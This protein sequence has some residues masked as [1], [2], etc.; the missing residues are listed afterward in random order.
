MIELLA[1]IAT[2]VALPFA[3]FAILY[4]AR[5]LSLARRAGSA[6]SVIALNDSL[7]DCWKHFTNSSDSIQRTYAFADLANAL[8]LACAAYHDEVFFG[9]TA[10]I[11]ENYLLRVF[12]LIEKNDDARKMM[13]EL[14]QTNTTFR[15]TVDFLANHRDHD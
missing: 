1:A 4:A 6:G 13:A 5:Q 9:R 7:R 11:L 8:E 12:R 10:D 15:N 14:I 2:I 3:I